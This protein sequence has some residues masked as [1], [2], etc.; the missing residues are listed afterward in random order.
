MTRS[1]P[2][3]VLVSLSLVAGCS[4]DSKPPSVERS[5]LYRD[6]AGDGSSTTSDGKPSGTE[7]GPPAGDAGKAADAPATGCL[8]EC[9]QQYE[10]LCVK[11]TTGTCKACLSDQHCTM[12]P[13]S[14][15]PFC[16]LA[17]KLCVCNVTADCA[18][19]TAGKKCLKVGNYLMCT[20]ETDADCAAP[21]SV[22]GGTV[23]KRCEK[24]CSSNADCVKGGFTGTCDTKTGKCEYS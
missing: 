7:K 23:I 1:R 8:P 5:P 19:S 24:P 4:D 3:L 14:D 13:R 21:Y 17:A 9:T 22:C 18:S 20:C 12:N 11:D 2:L 6:A 10:Y 16:D 15:G